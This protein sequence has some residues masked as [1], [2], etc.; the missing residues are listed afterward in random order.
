MKTMPSGPASVVPT[1]VTVLV[2]A[3]AQEAMEE[4]AREF[5][6]E[7]GVE[8]DVSVGASNSLAQ[9]ILAGAPADLFLSASEEWAEAL[10]DENLIGQRVDL[11]SNELVLVVPRGNPAGL[12][13]P[14]DLLGANVE[15][16]ALA[17]ENVPAGRY[18]EQA[19]T[20]LDLFHEL[21]KLDKI[22]RGHDVR[23]TLAFVER[24]EAEAGIVYA[25]DALAAEQIEVVYR[26]D[27]ATH[28]PI[29]YPLVLLNAG[30]TNAAAVRLFDRLQTP[31]S[32]KVFRS[33][34][35][36]PVPTA[37]AAR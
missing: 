9:Q 37:S 35:F 14:N 20:K 12:K 30:E 27:P 34:G 3:S 6:G 16:L 15:H 32:Q 26:F 1:H 7:Q 4:I 17:E 8:V 31:E 21:S 18:A 33:R 29:V 2:A 11:L 13:E 10:A 25:T 24:G 36:E 5:E 19:L 28:D 23:A 22:A